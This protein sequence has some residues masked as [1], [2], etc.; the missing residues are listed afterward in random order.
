MCVQEPKGQ[1]HSLNCQNNPPTHNRRFISQLS[2]VWDT[3]SP[4][5][6]PPKDPEN[7][8][9]DKIIKMMIAGD[10]ISH[11]MEGDWTWRYRLWKWCKSWADSL[12]AVS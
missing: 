3:Q 1:E 9:K 4:P 7:P 5:T 11:G 2:C 6:E 10:S 12:T 8:P